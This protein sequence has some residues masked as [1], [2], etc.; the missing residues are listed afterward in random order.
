MESCTAR[1]SSAS[2]VNGFVCFY[3]LVGTYV[4]FGGD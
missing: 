1:G 3:L 4:I 2:P